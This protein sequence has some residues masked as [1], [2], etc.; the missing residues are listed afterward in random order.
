M[1]P[2]ETDRRALAIELQT[3]ASLVDAALQLVTEH[4]SEL[5]DDRR[6]QVLASA[7]ERAHHIAQ[8]LDA[9]VSPAYVPPSSSDPGP[10][11]GALDEV[12]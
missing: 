6:Q 10:L 4:W 8:R 12:E 1:G 3:S 9:T 11:D 5:S 2:D 7:R